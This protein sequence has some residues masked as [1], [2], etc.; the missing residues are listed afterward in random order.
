MAVKQTPCFHV[1]L[2]FLVKNFRKSTGIL[3]NS[4]NT[5]FEQTLQKLCLK[6]R[7]LEATPI[8]GEHME[9]LVSS[10][11]PILGF[12]F[13]SEWRPEWRQRRHIYRTLS[14]LRLNE[15]FHERKRINCSKR[16]PKSL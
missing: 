4:L 5:H 7:L 8:D 3:K 6:K 16:A 9:R 11:F 12:M 13:R 14:N 15:H 2:N 1:H 10:N